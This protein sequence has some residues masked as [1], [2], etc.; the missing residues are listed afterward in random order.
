MVHPQVQTTAEG[1]KGV[2]GA[3][4]KQFQQLRGNKKRTDTKGEKIESYGFLPR[5]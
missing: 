4:K 1:E 2:T 3:E 5:F